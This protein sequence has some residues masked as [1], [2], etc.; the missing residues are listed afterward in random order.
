MKNTVL[1]GL[2]TKQIL[3]TLLLIK[4]R[5]NDKILR[6]PLKGLRS[7]CKLINVSVHNYRSIKASIIPAP[8]LLPHQ[9]QDLSVGDIITGNESSN[10]FYSY[11]T[12]YSI[13]EVISLSTEGDTFKEQAKEITVKIVAHTNQW[14]DRRYVGN[15]CGVLPE[16]FKK[17]GSIVKIKEKISKVAKVAKVAEDLGMMSTDTVTDTV[18]TKKI[19]AQITLTIKDFTVGQRVVL[20]NL[21]NKGEPLYIENRNNTVGN[22]GIVIKIYK[23]SPWIKVEWGIGSFGFY[24]SSNL[25]L[26]KDVEPIFITTDKAVTLCLNGKVQLIDFTYP[27]FTEVKDMITSGKFEEAFAAMDIKK[28]IENFC[29]GNLKINGETIT[30]RGI[31]LKNGI[32]SKILKMMKDG[33]KGFKS[34][35]KFMAKVME[36]PSLQTRERLLVFAEAEDIDISE[37]GDLI[38]FK[39]VRNDFQPSRAGCWVK[40]EGV[41]EFEYNTKERYLNEVGCVCEM[42]RSEVEDN[43]SITCAVG[44]HV[45]SVSYLLSMWGTSGQTMKV[46]VNPADFVAI[47][48]DYN[49][50]KARVCKYTVVEN[51][52]S[53]LKKYLK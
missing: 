53:D 15:V 7:C 11:T 32:T 3:N 33:D 14:N 2:S 41:G 22:K 20:D 12:S 43:E 24:K 35:A 8:T 52:T 13:C 9:S 36:N 18:P 5:S 16:Y 10:T 45:C 4:D 28:S 39:N 38:C 26:L 17:I 49:N 31:P 50:S 34:F 51:V 27:R 42:P 37:E 1:T 23:D 30:Y 47:P 40:H 21:L 46:H 44:L 25:R 6:V 19:G 29:L 48:T